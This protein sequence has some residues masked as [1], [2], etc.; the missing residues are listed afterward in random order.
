M[1]YWLWLMILGCS[2]VNLEMPEGDIVPPTVVEILPTGSNVLPNTSIWVFFNEAVVF[3]SEDSNLIVLAPA[4]EA[5]EAFCKD[6]NSPPLSN[7]RLEK[8]ISSQV[9]F[10]A[11]QNVVVLEPLQALE[12]G[13]SYRVVVSAAVTDMAGNPLVDKIQFDD[14][15]RATGLQTHFVHEFKTVG[16]SKD[17]S[18]PEEPDE[19]EEPEAEEPEEPEEHNPIEVGSVVI[20][21]VMANPEGTE[22]AGEYVEIVNIGSVSLEMEGW[23]F[24]DSS[25]AGNDDFLT[26]CQDGQEAILPPQGVALLVGRDFSAFDGIKSGTLILC[27]QRRTITSRGLKNSAGEVLV[28]KDPGGQEICRYGGW[29]D[30]SSNE[31][32]SAQRLDWSKPDSAENWSIFED[33][34]C[35]T[36]GWMVD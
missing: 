32:C 16:T 20:T 25:S 5:D 3:S 31:G 21:E 36:P 11:Q 1:K 14:H 23:Q 18:E 12:G 10:I 26:S 34:E 15:Q 17:S 22:S 4:E 6:F 28:L 9:Q 13:R 8:T 7:S 29:L 24:V 33:N 30:L 19:P 2:C 27:S 35:Q